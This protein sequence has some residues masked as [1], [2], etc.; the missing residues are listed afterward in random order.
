MDAISKMLAEAAKF[1][2]DEEKKY[3]VLKSE[4]EKAKETIEQNVENM[5]L[6]NTTI[7]KIRAASV[8]DKAGA[9]KRI[10]ALEKAALGLSDDNRKLRE[11]YAEFLN[12]VSGN[13]DKPKYKPAQGKP[14]FTIKS[15]DDISR[16]AGGVG[17]AV[18][19]D[20]I[21]AWSLDPEWPNF[22][23]LGVHDP[24]KKA[25]LREEFIAA[26]IGDGMPELEGDGEAIAYLAEQVGIKVSA[27][28]KAE[29]D[30]RKA[31]EGR[32]AAEKK[33]LAE[34]PVSSTVPVAPPIAPPANEEKALTDKQKKAAALAEAKR[35][36]NEELEYEESENAPRG[37]G[38]GAK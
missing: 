37:K 28:W 9:E 1:L 25:E 32:K 5:R 31:E 27:R 19:N 16:L 34:T 3:S 11:K 26:H 2:D 17:V 14:K 30:R 36:A 4:A 23:K 8:I 22:N 29:S 7:D 20:F 21:E 33:A 15:S 10:E 24:A 18:V 38:K 6:A 35:L 13:Q 12:P